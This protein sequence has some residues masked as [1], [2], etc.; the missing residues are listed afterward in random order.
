MD[1][2]QELPDMHLAYSASN[3]T[4]RKAGRLY[5]QIHPE[6]LQPHH[7]TFASN[8]LRRKERGNLKR[9]IDRFVFLNRTNILSLS[10]LFT[11]SLHWRRQN[12]GSIGKHY[13]LSPESYHWCGSCPR[14]ASTVEFEGILHRV[15][16][17]KSTINLRRDYIIMSDSNGAIV[18]RCLEKLDE[19]VEE[20]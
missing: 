15:E 3:C 14:T 16:E 4:E 8:H 2:F 18:W 1:P 12:I 19:L 5:E 9:T 6:C 11:S 7:I 20:I 10:F 17:N 13:S